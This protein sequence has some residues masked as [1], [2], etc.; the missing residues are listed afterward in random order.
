M[1][2]TTGR[3]VMALA[4][5][6][7]LL[8]IGVLEVVSERVGME[9]AFTTA[10][11]PAPEEREQ[12]W[13]TIAPPEAPDPGLDAS[14]LAMS[15]QTGRVTVLTV[16]QKARRLLAA[17]SAGRLVASEV[18]GAAASPLALLQPGDVIR[19]EPAV[20]TIQKI[21]LLRRAW[22]ELESPEQ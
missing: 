15:V 22:Q 14:H 17:N 19:I 10:L 6:V 8:G 12:A 21:V 20:G 13:D 3:V 11:R 5:A 18:S 4:V 2:A 1:N 7:C 16:D 9:R